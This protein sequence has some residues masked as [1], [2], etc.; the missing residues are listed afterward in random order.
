MSTIDNIIKV[1]GYDQSEFLFYRND[2]LS[3][4][5]NN[6]LSLHAY[7]VIR[8]LNPYAVYCVENKPFVLFFEYEYNSREYLKT[9]FKKI[10]NAQIPVVIISFEG[11][12]GIYNGCSLNTED[13]E[14]LHVE[15]VSNEFLSDTSIF[16]FWN[17]SSPR[18]WHIYA[19][20]F[21]TPTLDT[22]MLNNIK[23]ITNVLKRSPCAPFA[24]QII[25]RL[26]FIRFLI[27]RGV[28][29]NYKKFNSDIA[30]SRD[31][32][33]E[34][35]ESKDELYSLFSHLKRKF[36]GNLFEL[37]KDIKSGKSEC[38][39][40][41]SSSLAVLR[42]FMSGE[43]VLDTGQYSLFPL[44]DFNI[45]PIE[46][47]SAIYERFLG[48][49]K[50]KE[51]KAFY[52]PPYLVDYVLD[53]TIK[54]HLKNNLTCTV[55]DPACGSGIFLVQTARNLIENSLYEEENIIYDDL[56]VNIVTNNIF[57]IDKN[58]EAIDVAIFSIYLTVLDYKDPKTLKDF[59]LPMLKGKNFFVC[60]F[61]SEEVDY[62]LR[63]K[64][65]DFIIGN[66]PWGRVDDGLHI[67]YCKKNSLP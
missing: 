59:K 6:N 25:L 61:F 55:L 28:D 39:I 21:S 19:K 9:L 49:V 66:P 56:L 57:G 5:E 53:Q 42:D 38:D 23:Y 64:H 40:L 16:S 27:D 24:V 50:Q 62:L 37:Y 22:V 4:R 11:H 54:P 43:L 52:T 58:S 10:W 1:L 51:D 15:S 47:I 34:V 44:Y 2:F 63:D 29:L 12:I 30:K 67:E 41:D 18:F 7:R 35:M 14:L 8:E 36:N 65:F 13:H 26:I 17:I 46:L 3:K 60:D 32:L 31:Y 20:K 48:E 33:L 45:I